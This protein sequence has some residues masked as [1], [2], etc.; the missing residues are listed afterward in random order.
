MVLPLTVADIEFVAVGVE[1]DD[2]FLQLKSKLEIKNKQRII[3][4]LFI[5]R[6]LEL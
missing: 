5:I 1:E 3:I 2:A 6:D 4:L